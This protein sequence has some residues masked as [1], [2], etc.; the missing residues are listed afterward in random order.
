[1]GFQ[2][3]Q[4]GSFVLAGIHVESEF[5]G[6]NRKSEWLGEAF[7]QLD[8]R[9]ADSGIQGESKYFIYHIVPWEG[10][11]VGV[12]VEE[13]AE[14]PPGFIAIPIPDVKYRIHAH[15][16]PMN[17][18]PQT[19]D[20]ICA[21]G[22]GE[23]PDGELTH[24][25][26]YDGL[27]D[28]EQDRGSFDIWIPVKTDEAERHPSDHPDISITAGPKLVAVTDKERSE[29]Y[30]IDVLGFTKDGCGE[31]HRGELKLLLDE[32]PVSPIETAWHCYAYTRDDL[33]LDILYEELLSKG[34]FVSQE[35]HMTSETWKE[36]IVQDYDGNKIAFGANVEQ[37]VTLGGS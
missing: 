15:R 7:R 9:L 3:M 24:F 30:Y 25:E 11:I 20:S 26:K 27:F 19:F 23:P 17:E 13:G 34:A 35:P 5:P 21:S 4:R 29:N 6:W 16:G 8:Q 14:L 36:F 22:H 12:E 10:F 31:L 18:Q 32:G 28:F 37:R 2:T 33:Q 1:M